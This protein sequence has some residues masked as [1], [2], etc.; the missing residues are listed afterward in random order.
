MLEDLSE[1]EK[2]DV[3]TPSETPKRAFTRNFSDLQ[4]WSDDDKGKRL[5]I[6]LISYCVAVIV[7]VFTSINEPSFFSFWDF[8]FWNGYN[9]YSSTMTVYCPFKLCSSN[10]INTDTRFKF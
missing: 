4:V 10:I 6:V 3:A 7:F 9:E 8:H 2:T 1:G 5:Y